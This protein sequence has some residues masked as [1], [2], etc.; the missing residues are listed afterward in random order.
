VGTPNSDSV[1]TAG[2]PTDIAVKGGWLRQLVQTRLWP[3]F[4]V[5]PRCDSDVVRHQGS[6]VF[7]FFHNLHPW[8]NTFAVFPIWEVMLFYYGSEV[9]IDCEDIS[10][11]ASSPDLDIQRKH[12]LQSLGICPRPWLFVAILG[13]EYK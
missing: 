4:P 5:F 8:H 6:V 2:E 11:H 12:G 1:L 7:L 10:G 3:L 9:R 13:R